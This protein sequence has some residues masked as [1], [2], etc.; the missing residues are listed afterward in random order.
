MRSHKEDRRISRILVNNFNYWKNC[1][2]YW[3]IRVAENDDYT[4]VICCEWRSDYVDQTLKWF[5][6]SREAKSFVLMNIG[7][8]LFNNK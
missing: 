5:D 1:P 8:N 6:D 7:I 2:P 3:R 4:Y